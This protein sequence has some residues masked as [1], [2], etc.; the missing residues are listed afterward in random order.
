VSSQDT[1]V[2]TSLNLVRPTTGSAY[3]AVI[4]RRIGSASYGARIVVAPSGSVK[5]QIR[6]TNTT[7]VDLIVPGL[8]Y[9]PGNRLQLRLQVT[10]VSPTAIRAKVWKVGTAEPSTWQ[11]SKSDSTA[12][13]QSVGSIGLV[14]YSGSNAVPS[15]LVVSVE[16]LWAGS[17]R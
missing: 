17:T 5:L 9:T 11:V 12:G 7:V 6:R 15:P 3:I 8:T 16:E 13:L 1:E 4:G 10:G 2:R 14:L